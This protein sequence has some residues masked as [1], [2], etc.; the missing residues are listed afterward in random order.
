[1]NAG[2]QIHWDT[3]F[4]VAVLANLD[5]PAAQLVLDYVRAPL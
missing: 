1:M 2:L 4:N 3:G 5:P